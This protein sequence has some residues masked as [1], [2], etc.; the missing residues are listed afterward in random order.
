MTVG[1]LLQGLAQAVP[2][3]ERPLARGDARGADVLCRGV[4]YD[5]RRVEAGWVFVAIRGLTADGADFAHK[6]IAAGA[7]AVVAER[8]SGVVPAAGSASTDPPGVPWIVVK[9]ARLALAALA[10]VFFGHPSREMS[11]VGITGDQRQDHD[12][13]SRG[14]DL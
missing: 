3:D 6:A 1:E 7:A 12:Q 9:D 5:S 8:E 13:L 10:S 11:V 14:F 4:T 2:P